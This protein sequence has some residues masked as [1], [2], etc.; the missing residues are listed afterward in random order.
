MNRFLVLACA[1]V[2]AAP[3]AAL[4]APPVVAVVGDD[5]G[6]NVLHQE[7]RALPGEPVVYPAGMP[8]PRFVDLPSGASFGD[9]LAAVHD[10][11]LSH[12]EPGV[13]YAVRGTRLLL[14]N[15]GGTASY[16][17]A[18]PLTAAPGSA[19]GPRT[20]GTGVISAAIGTTTGTQPRGLAVF[21]TAAANSVEAWQWIAAQPWIDVAT[22]SDYSPYVGGRIGDVNKEEEP[23]TCRSA[24]ETHAAVASGHLVFSSSGNTTD[25]GEQH[26]APNGLAD[27][28]QVGGTDANGR[29]FLPGDVVNPGDPLWSAQ[30][31]TRPYQTGALEYFLTAGPDSYDGWFQFG[32]TSGATPKTAGYAMRLI[33]AAR[34]ILGAGRSGAALATLGAGAAPP[35]RGPLADGKLTVDELATLLHHTARPAEAATP[36]RYAIEGYGAVND[37]SVA[38]ALQVLSGQTAEPARPDEDTV[39]DAV[40]QARAGY[41]SAKCS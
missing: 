2:A 12:L 10:G 22:M 38:T 24:R 23:P 18:V 7:F 34:G 6:V 32:G 41:F 21:L 30:T 27:V 3:A 5:D 15:P 29:T 16:E 36:L 13:L 35:V 37:A 28:Y 19:Y 20:H 8:T 11:P 9:A 4:G 25:P 33:E 14:F 31:P 26:F 39:H 1:L 17:D 40:L